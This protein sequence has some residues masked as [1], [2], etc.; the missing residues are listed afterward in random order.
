V[1]FQLLRGTLV[2]SLAAYRQN[3]TQLSGLTPVVQGTRAKGVELEVRWLASEHLS[4]TFTGNTQ[5]TTVK[6]P[7]AS[8][9]YIPAY[10]AGVPGRAG[11]WRLY[12]VWSFAACRGAAATT[13][14]P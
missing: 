9:Q 8:F 11:L 10:T 7:D 4:F 6:G 3:R 5:H 12:V 13:T 2:G 14:T 1:K